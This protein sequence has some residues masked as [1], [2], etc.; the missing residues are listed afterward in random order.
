MAKG[1]ARQSPP[2]E[3]GQGG[4]HDLGVKQGGAHGQ[5]SGVA[6]PVYLGSVEAVVVPLT[7]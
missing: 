3:V 6:E 1:W 4:S 7:A 2:P 5:R